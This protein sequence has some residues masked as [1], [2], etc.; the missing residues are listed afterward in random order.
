MS[1]RG[2]PLSSRP[3]SPISGLSYVFSSRIRPQPVI[4]FPD[5]GLDNTL[6]TAITHNRT[7]L[8]YLGCELFLRWDAT[9]ARV[10]F[11][12]SF[13]T[14][15]TASQP[16][17]RSLFSYSHPPS[18]NRV[19]CTCFA[20]WISQLNTTYTALSNVS[21]LNCVTNRTSDSKCFQRPSVASYRL[22]SAPSCHNT[23]TSAETEFTLISSSPGS[24]RPASRR[25][26]KCGRCA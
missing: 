13:K 22:P 23:M 26:H 4:D 17:V 20:A 3:I 1:P 19:F 15:P 24:T 10:G 8:T 21:A 11:N 12:G 9:G 2:S 5:I 18:P 16:Q 25:V 6:S 14:N 7:L